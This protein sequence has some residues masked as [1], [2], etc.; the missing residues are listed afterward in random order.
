MLQSNQGLRER[1]PIS[2]HFDDYSAAELWE[3]AHYICDQ[4]RFTLTPEAD[5]RLRRYIEEE[6]RVRNASFSNARWVS[7]L[8]FQGVI[9][10]MATRVNATTSDT[11]LLRLYTTIEEADVIAAVNEVSTYTPSIMERSHIGFR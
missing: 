9:K 3:I 6:T 11:D 10:Q 4:R 5:E 1:F 8:M 7:N 2:I